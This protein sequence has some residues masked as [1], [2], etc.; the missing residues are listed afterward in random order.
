MD[1]I[2][3]FISSSINNT[4]LWISNNPKTAIAIAIFILGFLIGILF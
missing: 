2:L 1:K 4:T 3:Q